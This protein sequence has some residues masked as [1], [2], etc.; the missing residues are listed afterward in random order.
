MSADAFS[1]APFGSP[2]H[3]SATVSATFPSS[4]PASALPAP[5]CA[6]ACFFPAAGAPPPPRPPLPAPLPPTLPLPPPRQ[7]DCRRMN[8]PLGRLISRLCGF[9][10]GIMQRRQHVFVMHHG[11][12]A[13]AADPLWARREGAERAWDPPLS[14]W[15]KY[16]A[17][18][19][20]M[21]L[22]QEGWGV[23]RIVCAPYLRCVETALE[24]L[25]ALT[26]AQPLPPPSSSAPT[27]AASAADSDAGAGGGSI[28]GSFGAGSSRISSMVPGGMVLVVPAVVEQSSLT[29]QPS[30]ALPP[31]RKRKFGMWDGA[32]QGAGGVGGGE[33]RVAVHYGLHEVGQGQGQNEGFCTVAGNTGSSAAASLAPRDWLEGMFPPGSV[34]RI[35]PVVARSAT[36]AADVALP[37]WPEDV[38]EAALRLLRS[39]DHVAE[40]VGIGRGAGGHGIRWALEGELVGM[41]SGGHWKGSWWAWNQVGI[42]RGAGGHGIRWAE[43]GMG[44]RDVQG[45]LTGG[46]AAA[47][48]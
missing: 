19:V 41:E 44:K 27:A 40:Q 34:D 35:L 45:G 17:Y 43:K 6:A 15:G 39:I 1:A 8:P 18:E 33:V 3:S 10:S 29:P 23:T 21:R 13:D 14:E 9:Q 36:A 48:N 16:Q 32:W 26:D 47:V 28:G 11:E 37:G 31:D 12:R 25:L 2:Y 7:V 20:S 30:L 42:G 46:V 5:S 22:R 24:L 4:F 38:E